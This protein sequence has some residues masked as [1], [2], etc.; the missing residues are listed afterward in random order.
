MNRRKTVALASS[1]VATAALLLAPAQPAYADT[2]LLKNTAS[3]QMGCIQAQGFDHAQ[4]TTAFCDGNDFQRWVFINVPVSSTQTFVRIRNVGSGL[5]MRASTN[6]D[7]A[8]VDQND[9][10]QISNELWGGL[11]SNGVIKSEISTGG[12]PCLDLQQGPS[13]TIPK[14]IDVFHCTSNNAAQIFTAPQVT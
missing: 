9:C 8:L 2:F 11:E 14:P 12:E 3:G 7:F 1:F 13:T 10:T 4:L 6:K 5:C